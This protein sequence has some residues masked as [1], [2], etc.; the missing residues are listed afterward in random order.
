M[1]N[2]LF[3]RY[4]AALFF[5]IF[6]ISNLSSQENLALD[7]FVHLSYPDSAGNLAVD[8]NDNTI[9]KT[10]AGVQNP[11]IFIDLGKSY[12]ISKIKINNFSLEGITTDFKDA[13]LYY[14]NAQNVKHWH[15]IPQFETE[16]E[17]VKKG[18]II[19]GEIHNFE[20]NK[21]VKAQYIKIFIRGK[22][23][24]SVGEIEVYENST[25]SSEDLF[26]NEDFEDV[27]D[28]MKNHVVWL[29]ENGGSEVGN[30]REGQYAMRFK[31]CGD[32]I[33][34]G[35]TVIFK[36]FAT[37][38]ATETT[39]AIEHKGNLAVDG[40]PNTIA[41][42]NDIQNPYIYI[43]LGRS[44]DI[45]EIKINKFSFDSTSDKP[46]NL[47][48]SNSSDIKEWS[49]ENFN[50]IGKL[51]E[52]D[53]LLDNDI[54]HFQVGTVARY[55]KIFNR[56]IGSFSVAEVEVYDNS[57]T[58]YPC[59]SS[60]KKSERAEI[61]L[62][63]SSN[64]Y[65]FEWGEEYWVGFSFKPI[66][67]VG[68]TGEWG[69]IMQF[70]GIPKDEIFLC[71]EE[72]KAA[73]PDE[74]CPISARADSFALMYEKGTA[75]NDLVI[76]TA[77]DSAFNDKNKIEIEEIDS[78]AFTGLEPHIA[79]ILP[80][81]W[82]DVVLHFKLSESSDD[83][84]F[85]VI[86]NGKEEVN[87]PN[88]STV[89]KWG[90][91]ENKKLVLKERVDYGKIGI[92]GGENVTGEIHYDAFRVW[93]GTGGNCSKVAPKDENNKPFFDCPDSGRTSKSVVTVENLL[94]EE[95]N[96]EY[97]INIYPNPTHSSVEIA[98]NSAE[99]KITAVHLFDQLG[100]LL[101][102]REVDHLDS[103]LLNMTEK[104]NGIY[105]IRVTTN[106]NKSTSHR[107]LINN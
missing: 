22:L 26:V 82:N 16:E 91:D 41:K 34:E 85:K 72:W 32:N 52:N 62:N 48:V 94:V 89:Y 28:L 19:N 106:N 47:Y 56:G 55:I 97:A 58:T 49:L 63:W 93:K 5:I 39:D 50:L 43:D 35:K 67:Q 81:K 105:F 86:V 71:S 40:N 31:G 38:D 33:A 95:N 37:T 78:G 8:D 15:V 103:Y 87:K 66:E 27:D 75:I 11:Y 29:P 65:G 100:K 3:Y 46:T 17:L 59:Q 92:Y 57:I 18:E 64:S 54:H 30:A 7:K 44:Y 84:F 68:G 21:D 98:L 4:L 53:E 61:A 45:S 102:V 1:K 42:T 6:N 60:T 70:H 23:K 74:D 76:L 14:S 79:K 80:G 101:E 104:P 88:T 24:F 25:G 77:T 90:K 73:N 107:L 96:E 10:I 2:N 51:S 69:S 9:A 12:N 83:G 13:K 99:E 36:N 20:V